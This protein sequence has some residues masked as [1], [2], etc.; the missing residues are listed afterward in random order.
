MAQTRADTK[1]QSLS[2]VVPWGKVPKTIYSQL[3]A[4]ISA[5]CDVWGTR[6][7][8]CDVGATVEKVDIN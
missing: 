1:M 7:Q 3:T 2:L 6:T 8:N 5:W 4:S